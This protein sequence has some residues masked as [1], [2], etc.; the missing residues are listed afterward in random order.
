MEN[1]LIHEASDS[2]RLEQGHRGGYISIADRSTI[3][4]HSGPDMAI[5]IFEL[6]GD[7]AQADSALSSD[8]KV[9]V[10]VLEEYVQNGVRKTSTVHPTLQVMEQS[11]RTG[12]EKMGCDQLPTLEM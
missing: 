5:R 6:I 8:A 9:L 10:K 4:I 3:F 2:A 11:L 12:V 1:K 7:I